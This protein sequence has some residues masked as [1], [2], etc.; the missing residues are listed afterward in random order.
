MSS[1]PMVFPVASLEAYRFTSA[2]YARRTILLGPTTGA[3][4][5]SPR[6][7]HFAVARLTA[8]TGDRLVLTG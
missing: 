6:G 3:G 7:T 5:P 1:A 4:P 8:D 2:G